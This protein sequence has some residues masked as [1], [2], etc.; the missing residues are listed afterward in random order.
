VRG[1]T[2]KS[3]AV[4]VIGAFSRMITLTTAGSNTLASLSR[5]F[6]MEG[7]EV[8]VADNP[9]RALMRSQWIILSRGNYDSRTVAGGIGDVIG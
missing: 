4:N 3:A 9:A 5:A 2:A 7:Y 6:P 8:T 1:R